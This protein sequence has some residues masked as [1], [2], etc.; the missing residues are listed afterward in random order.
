M[1]EW[2]PLTS[3]MESEDTTGDED[4][5]DE[6]DVEAESE[7]AVMPTLI[8][9]ARSAAVKYAATMGSRSER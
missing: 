7:E 6:E 9:S 1:P 4:E 8:S 5:E 3:S 2:R